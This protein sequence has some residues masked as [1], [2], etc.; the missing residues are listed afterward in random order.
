MDFLVSVVFSW[1]DGCDVFSDGSCS[2][3]D[4]FL[5]VVDLVVVLFS[6]SVEGGFGAFDLCGE[7]DVV[8]LSVF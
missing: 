1:V 2:S 3:V 5:G 7:V 8:L 6:D 4:A